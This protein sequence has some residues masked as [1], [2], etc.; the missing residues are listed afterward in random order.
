MRVLIQ[1]GVKYNSKG[2]AIG[3]RYN[4]VGHVVLPLTHVYIHKDEHG[5]D[6][7]RVSCG[8]IWSIKRV[9]NPNYEYVTV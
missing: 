4:K 6:V 9:N 2:D 3:T 5:N 1:H 8:D 7:G